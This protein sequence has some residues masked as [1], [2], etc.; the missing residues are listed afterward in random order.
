MFY[1]QYRP[2]KVKSDLSSGFLVYNLYYYGDYQYT[3]K[4]M[5]MVIQVDWFINII[6]LNETVIIV[7]VV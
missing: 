6:S 1:V 3:L 7:T 4:K 5:I 2:F